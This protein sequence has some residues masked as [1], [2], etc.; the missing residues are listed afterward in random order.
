M[1]W[2]QTEFLLKGIYLGLLLLVGLQG[3]T[4]TEIAVVGLCMLGGLAVCLGVA[5]YRKVREGYRVRGRLAGFILFL[6]LENPGLVYTG[7][8]VGLTLGAYTLFKTETDWEIIAPVGGGA[9]L[10]LIFWYLRHAKRD[11]RRWASLVLAVLLV[12]GAIA[13]LTLQPEAYS[14][15]TRQTVG[16]LLLLGIPGFYLLTFA[17]VVEESEIE[18]GAICA[19][20]GVALWIFGSGSSPYTG[21]A[22]MFI[23]LGVYFVYTR[24]IL[25]GLRVFK[26]VL[27]GMSYAN[28][29]RYRWALVSLGRAL[30]LAP[31]HPLA[32]QHLWKLHQEMD[33]DQLL[34]DPETLAVV[35]YE[36]CLERVAWLLLLDR[37]KPAHLE[38]AHKLLDLVES[39]RPALL[40]RC[41]YWRAVAFTHQKEFDKAA[42]ALESILVAP[43]EDTPQRRAVLLPAWQLALMLHPE[44]KRRVGDPLVKQPDRRLEA[45]AAAERQIAMKADDPAAWDLKRLLYSELT[46]DIYHAG[47]GWASPTNAPVGGAHPTVGDFDYGYVEQL[48]LALIEKPDEW[49]RG[50]EYLR[51]AAVGQPNKAPAL[52]LTIA[53]AHE[54]A[55]DMAGV[56]ANYE[57]A[58]Q[59]GRA[60]GPA[61]LAEADRTN[62]FAAVKQLADHAREVG[63]IDQALDSFKFYTLND[64]AGIETYRALAEL[65]E[66]KAEQSPEQ[67]ADNIWNALNCTEHALSYSSKDPDLVARKDK[68]YYSVTPDEVKARWDNIRLWFDVD[69]CLTKARSVLEQKTVDLDLLDW[70]NHLADLAQAAKPDSLAAKVVRARIKR[71]RGEISEGITLLEEVRAGKPEKFASGDDEEAWYLAHRLLG[72]MYIDDKP[73]QAVQCLREYQKNPKSGANTLYNLGRAY[74]NLGDF[75]RAAKYYEQVTAYEGNPLVYEAQDALY[76]VKQQA[77]SGSGAG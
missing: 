14:E 34:K 4:W 13:F 9:A 49:Q 40:P 68:Y 46:E 29:G 18:I 17:S 47:V 75:K 57:R 39:Q 50:A 64:R 33:L 8:L 41:L 62:L 2:D 67:K 37:P 48:G 65:F 3:P 60:I 73:D 28:V 44:M 25:P 72:E 51:I 42:A 58:K 5:G 6:L 26:H 24:R 71:Q 76:R 12:G 69:Y 35:N 77:E 63:D 11:V 23:P 45:I 43:A 20:L 61:N 16:Y 22:A 31:D 1:R 59:L 56:W 38:E 30:E 21:T 10:G 74:E 7:L 70:G 53:K 55:G 36:L 66:K 27:R 54:K 32:R 52:Y 15:Q 19:A